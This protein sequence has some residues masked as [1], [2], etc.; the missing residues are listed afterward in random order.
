M[1]DETLLTLRQISQ[2]LKL[3]EST[4]RYYRDLFSA[5]LPTVGMGRRRR[6]PV[7]AVPVFRHIASGYANG[8]SKEE[9]E[10]ALSLATAESV[11][12]EPVLGFGASTDGGEEP[13]S[14]Y[15]EGEQ[16]RRDAMWQM[17]R[18][19]VRLG[20][21]ID[22]QGVMI[23]NLAKQL[24]DQANR[25]LPSTTT[26]PISQ[27]SPAP[28][29][30]P[31]SAQVEAEK[32]SVETAT[33][34]TVAAETLRGKSKDSPP[35]SPQTPSGDAPSEEDEGTVDELSALKEEL[36]RE[37]DLVERL[38]KSKLD[39]ERRAADAESRLGYTA[40]PPV[41]RSS[42]PSLFTRFFNKG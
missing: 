19:I 37:R 38:R 2:E 42:R 24:A 23:G 4:V 18:E 35:S 13:V 17:A 30:E 36:A 27:P 41:P 34:E 5:Y 39:I 8:K 33:P 25:T 9:I 10:S 7:N 16:D 22:R 6:Y 14:R 28:L 12:A 40:E 1:S 15:L 32:S 29:D 21:T 26:E 20:E 11:E 3:P 31:G